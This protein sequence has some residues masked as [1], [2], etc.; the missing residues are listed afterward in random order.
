M[1]PRS[2]APLPRSYPA[3]WTGQKGQAKRGTRAPSPVGARVFRVAVALYI[4]VTVARTHG[5]VPGLAFLRPGKLLILPLVASA[6]LA[7]PRWQ[8]LSPLRTTTAKC[9]GVII[10]LGTFGI[11]LAIWPGNSATFL[12]TV[13]L[14]LLPL[15]IGASAAFVDRQTASLCIKA[16]VFAVGADA[17]YVLA[18][19][20]P[21]MAGRP[22]IG[23]GLDPN[24][25]AALFVLSFPFALALGSGRRMRWLGFAIAGLLAAGVV[26]TGSRGGVIGMAIVALA[27]IARAGP[28]HRLKYLIAVAASAVVVALAADDTLIERMSTIAQ[29]REDY[30]ITDREGRL[31]IWTRGLGYMATH[32]VLGIGLANF[33]TAEGVLSGKI[34]RG[35]GVRYTAAH[36]AFVQIGAELGVLGLAAFVAAFWSAARGCRRVLRAAARDHARHPTLADDEARLAA[37]ALC[38]LLGVAVTGFFLSLAYHPIT[39]FAL[40]ACIGVRVGSPYESRI[41]MR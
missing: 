3:A 9:V 34:N 41:S 27:L 24:E 18:G 8:L 15:F 21:L 16:L 5:V 20:A 7:V 6:L 33:E 31:Q 37:A 10:A 11:P 38:A 26:K 39:L 23:V 1:P 28:R 30:N 22:Y 35:Y 40:A 32:P 29:P 2:L 4:I 12:A 36:N 25:T 17:L 13:L 14:P 19:L